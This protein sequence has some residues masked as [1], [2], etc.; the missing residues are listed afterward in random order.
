MRTS[1]V[2]RIVLSGTMTLLPFLRRALSFTST[3]SRAKRTSFEVVVHPVV[4]NPTGLDLEFE[5]VQLQVRRWSDPG[6]VF[7]AVPRPSLFHTCTTLADV[8]VSNFRIPTNAQLHRSEMT[9]QVQ[10][11]TALIVRT[12]RALLQFVPGVVT[13]QGVWARIW[14]RTR[15]NQDEWMA[16]A[17]QM[18]H[19]IVDALSGHRGRYAVAVAVSQC[20]LDNAKALTRCE[21]QLVDACARASTEARAASRLDLVLNLRR[22]MASVTIPLLQYESGKWSGDVLTGWDQ[23]GM[24]VWCVN[25]VEAHR[26]QMMGAAM[27]RAAL[28]SA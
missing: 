28:Q 7:G 5:D 23:S 11:D 21:P 1:S 2:M 12:L 16:D 15:A 26:R 10:L 20:V 8:R 17:R 22:G 4:S 19:T 27:T 3:I 25:Y 18:I 14:G 13:L 6:I 9:L 24:L